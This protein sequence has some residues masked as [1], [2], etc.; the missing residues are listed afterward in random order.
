LFEALLSSNQ[1]S[2]STKHYLLAEDLPRVM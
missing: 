1:S 2:E